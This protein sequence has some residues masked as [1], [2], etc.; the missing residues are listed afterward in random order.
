[1]PPEA[2][3]LEDAGAAH[4]PGVRDDKEVVAAVQRLEQLGLVA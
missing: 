3:G 2:G 1:M 4:V